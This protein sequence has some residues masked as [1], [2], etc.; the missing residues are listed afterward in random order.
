[1]EKLQE[2]IREK[3]PKL[4][5]S[6]LK[7]YSSALKTLWKKYNDGESKELEDFEWL[8]DYKRVL[9]SMESLK[10]NTKK[11]RLSTII[12]A[13]DAMG[14]KDKKPYIKYQDLMVKYD[15]EYQE[16]KK[17]NAKSEKQEKNWVSLDELKAVLKSHE[18]WLK[19]HEVFKKDVLTTAEYTRLQNWVLGN[20]YVGDD[21]N[22]PTRSDY[23]P[24]KVVTA[25]EFGE[26]DE[27]EMDEENYLVVKSKN[28]KFFSLGE[29][30][31]R[32]KNGVI[33]INVGKDLN[34]VLNLWL[35]HNT[36]GYL[37]HDKN[38]NAMSTNSL[39]KNLIKV[40]KPTGKNISVNMLRHIYITEKY[41]VDERA[42]DARKMGH[43]VEEQ[44][45]YA[46]K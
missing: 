32:K 22:P 42:E 38:T 12:V 44:G 19:E 29:Y 25:K 35:R 6:T 34:R 15:A 7:T 20:L 21:E 8:K 3:R 4:S 16:F 14:E 1:M 41:P 9:K 45:K 10:D 39:T 24:M 33:R 26:L 30:K 27:K 36:S 11:A 28:K 46:K 43:S 5:E 23:T 18:A 37:L 31:M 13:L 40:F 2:Q 17:S